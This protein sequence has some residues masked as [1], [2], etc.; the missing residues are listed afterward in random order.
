MMFER[1]T[2]RARK[3]M[4][5]ANQ[6]AERLNHEFITTEHVLLAIVNEG[7]G[8]AAKMLT[9][10][11]GELS[12]IRSEVEKLVKP[13]PVPL[14]RGRRKAT[15]HAKRTIELAIEEARSVT[16][17]YVGTEHLLL[18]LLRQPDTIAGQALISRG[19]TASHVRMAMWNLGFVG[20]TEDAGQNH[21]I[22]K[23]REQ[24]KGHYSGDAM[25]NGGEAFEVFATYTGAA[26][27][28]TYQSRL[29]VTGEE[30]S[31]PALESRYM[32]SVAEQLEA[33]AAE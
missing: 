20:A 14:P 15:P 6:E 29:A 32:L 27:I 31:D 21:I 30:L 22:T 28:Y 11:Q 5:L 10:L 3:V 7:S 26:I 13:G 23:L 19:I 2:D 33:A 9:K 16:H 17:S 1:Y 4:G 25:L 8:S 18:G 12:I 24:L